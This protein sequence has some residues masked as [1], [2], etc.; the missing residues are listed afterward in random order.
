MRLPDST[1]PGA[2]EYIFKH[3]LERETIQK[4]DAAAAR[5][6]YHQGIADWIDHQDDDPLAARSTC[7]MLAQHREKA[8]DAVRAGLTYLDAGDLARARYANAQGLR[9]LRRRAS[10]CSATRRRAAASTRCTT[11]ATC[12]S[13]SGRVDDAL[14][15]FREMLTLAY[16]L[17]LTAQGRRR[18]QPHRPAVPRHRLARRRG[19]STSQ[20]A[21][22]LFERA[23]DERGVASSHRRHRQAPLAEGRVRAGARPRCATALARRQA[24]RRPPHHRAQSLNNLGLVLQDSGEFRQ[25]LEA[26]EQ[27]LTIRREIG[28]LVGVVATLNNLGTIAQDQRDFQQ[29][30]LAVRRGARGGEADRRPQPASRS[31][32]PTSARRTTAAAT[33]TRRSRCLQQAEELCDELGDKLGLAEALRGAG[34]GVPAAGRSGARRASASGAP[35]ICSRRCGARSTS[36]I[37]LRTLGEITAAGGWGAAHTKSAR[38]YFARSVAIFEQTGN[39]VELART[40]KVYARFLSTE[41]EYVDDETARHDAEAMSARADKIFERLR[42]SAGDRSGPSR[43]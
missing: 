24:A 12:S 11:T 1:F 15:A 16:R 5:R 31:C 36:A 18:A 13:S 28:D 8:G 26:F 29:R 25:A 34:Q 7:A 2:D 32:S 21:M 40:F 14:A 33:P 38:E 39:E 3:N 17:D 43:G 6:R 27:A 41:P 37:A 4:R 9:V 20:T 35:S 10:S 42:I 30:A 22:A 23:G 19:A